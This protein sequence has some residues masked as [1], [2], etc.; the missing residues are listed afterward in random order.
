MVL[1]RASGAPPRPDGT[2]AHGIVQICPTKEALSLTDHAYQGAGATVRTPY[3]GHHELPKRYQQFN[4]PTL[5]CVLPANTP[6][7]A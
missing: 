4:L 2:R 3:Y 1:T 6:L 5:D 7:L